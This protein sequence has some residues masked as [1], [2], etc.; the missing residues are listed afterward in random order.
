MFRILESIYDALGNTALTY[1]SYNTKGCCLRV[2]S[3]VGKG[4]AAGPGYGVSGP[5]FWATLC[6]RPYDIR[7]I[8]DGTRFHCHV[9]FVENTHKR[10]TK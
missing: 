5:T 1:L 6:G 10:I 8:S 4:P 2:G 3:R 9:E 7:G